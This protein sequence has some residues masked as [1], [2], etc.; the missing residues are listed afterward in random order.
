MII[1]YD[2]KINRKVRV[3]ISSTFS[4]MIKERDVLVHSVFPR[5]RREFSA[6]MID[7]MEVDLRWGIPEEDSENSQ[8]LEICIGEVLHCSPFFVGIVGHSYG[9]IAPPEE[10]E[11]LPPAYRQAIGKDVPEIVSYTELEMRAGV[12]V[13]NNTDY[14]CFFIRSDALAQ[15]AEP[16][17]IENLVR[18]IGKNYQTETYETIPDFEEK[19]YSCLKAYIRRVIP[20]KLETPYN[21]PYYFSHLK[22]LKSKA[23]RYTENQLFISGL[24]RRIAETRKIYLHGDKGSGKSA[25]MAW[26]IR[27]EGVERDRRVFFHFAA[28][29][30]ESLKTENA[31]YRLRKQ[32]ESELGRTSSEPGSREAVI[33]LLHNMPDDFSISLFFDAMDQMDD[34]TAV[35]QFLALADLSPGIQVVCSGTQRYLQIGG[36]NVVEM[37]QL[38]QDQISQILRGFLNRYGKKL[39]TSMRIRIMEKESCRNPLFLQAMISQLRMYGTFETL[40]QFFEKLIATDSLSSIFA[41]TV[42]RLKLYFTNRGGGAEKVDQALA[43]IVYSNNGI[44]ETEMQEMLQLMPVTRSVLFSAVELFIIEDNGL[45]RL[46]HDLLIRTVKAHLEKDYPDIENQ[47]AERLLSYFAQQPDDWRKYSEMPFQL[48]KLKKSEALLQML[49]DKKCFLYLARNEH[50]ALIGYLSALVDEQESLA[51]ALIGNLAR[52][53]VWITADTLCQSGCHH[54]AIAIARNTLK[55]EEN[56][57]LRIRMMDTLARSTYKLAA[58]NF[59]DAIDVYRELLAYYRSV[60]PQDEIGYAS[61]AYLLGVAYKSSGDLASAE[62]LIRKCAEIHEK[63]LVMNAT[64]LWTLDVYGETFFATGR[65]REGLV[66][67][68]RVLDRCERL[69]GR[70]SAE[71]AWAYCYGWDKIYAAGEKN[72]AL[73]MIRAA[74]EIYNRLYF[75]RGTKIAW[76]SVNAGTAAMID[77]DYEEAEKLYRFSIR[78]NDIILP[79]EERP[80]VYSLTTYANLACLQETMKRHQEAEETIRFALQESRVK[81]GENHIYT[82][83]IMLIRGIITCNSEDVRKAVSGYDAQTVRTP[84]C[85]FSRI[86]LIRLLVL[87]KRREEAMKELDLLE[88]A[89]FGQEHETGLITYLLL[90]TLDKMKGNLSEEQMDEYDLLYRFDE[91]RFYLTHNNNSQMVL[92]PR[93]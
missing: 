84:D 32:L 42:E 11:S 85:W 23:E 69:F 49:S 6:Q 27:R 64:S 43:L 45:I 14:S 86:C 24:E 71:M 59:R 72:R 2:K 8:I 76:A 61:R 67:L 80:H 31:F 19:I 89:Y 53:E 35:Y 17:K 93:I 63:N 38:T 26:L 56:P 39:S 9:S 54:A 77:G 29:G 58:R 36:E 79:E 12:F 30:N 87:E 70:N 20:E 28:A 52:E 5:L 3:F 81:N 90:D 13:P 22:V 44:R 18:Q 57:D 25:C 1:S 74:Y 91:Y 73:E 46:N 50:A 47:T 33:D 75:G 68:D 88:K 83:N 66:M 15:E 82:V 78:E 10:V 62:K 41:I 34:V 65:I 7:I 48:R 40:E 51:E 37:E 60:Y 21:D 16:S 92:I 55:T 4:D